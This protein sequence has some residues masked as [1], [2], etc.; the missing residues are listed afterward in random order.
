MNANEWEWEINRFEI[1]TDVDDN[2]DGACFHDA[3]QMTNQVLVHEPTRTGFQGDFGVAVLR[4]RQRLI[5]WAFLAGPWQPPD[6]IVNARIEERKHSSQMLTIC[7]YLFKCMPRGNGNIHRTAVPHGGF[8]FLFRKLCAFGESPF[9][10]AVT[11]KITE[12]TLCC[13]L[14]YSHF[15]VAQQTEDNSISLKSSMERRRA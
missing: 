14:S 4:A 8:E 7:A 6:T 9:A 12:K 1:Y 13:R 15:H 2:D 11:S 3:D 10:Y 5:G